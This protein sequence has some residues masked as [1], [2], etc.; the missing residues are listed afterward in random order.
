RAFVDGEGCQS[1]YSRLGIMSGLLASAGLSH[2]THLASAMASLYGA[3]AGESFCHFASLIEPAAYPFVRRRRLLLE[4]WWPK[5]FKS[6]MVQR[7]SNL[8]R[9]VDHL[10]AESE[11]GRQFSED[12]RHYVECRDPAL[13]RALRRQLLDWRTLGR[14]MAMH[15]SH[16]SSMHREGLHRVA[17]GL[18]IVAQ[19]GLSALRALEQRTPHGWFQRFFWKWRLWPYAYDIFYLDKDLL[20]RIIWELRKP[21]VLNRHHVAIYPGVSHLMRIADKEG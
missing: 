17:L 20:R 21:D 14:T 2:E 13:G 9:F 10:N 12:V 15:A 6:P 19:A 16:V 11:A 4:R 5:I 18:A 7:Y 1:L 8:R 3:D